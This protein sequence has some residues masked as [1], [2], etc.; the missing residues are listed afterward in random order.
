ML[1]VCGARTFNSYRYPHDL[2]LC[3]SSNCRPPGK[4]AGVIFPR[5]D[6]SIVERLVALSLTCQNLIVGRLRFRVGDLDLPERRKE[7][8]K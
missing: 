2:E 6:T 7:Y 8:R 5:S 3:T 4:D 1:G